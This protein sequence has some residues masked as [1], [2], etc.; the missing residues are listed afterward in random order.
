MLER[1]ATVF[2]VSLDYLVFGEAKPGDAIKDRDLLKLFIQADDLDYS[3]K[4]ALK[5][6][7]EG[8]IA[9]EQLKKAS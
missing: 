1:L 4:S 8:L 3:A 2:E 9:R 5:Q 7:I 6:I